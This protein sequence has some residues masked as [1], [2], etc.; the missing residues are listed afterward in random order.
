MERFAA[1]YGRALFPNR[2]AVRDDSAAGSPTADGE[3]RL[4][5][6]PAGLDL[7]IGAG[8]Y[9]LV[10]AVEALLGGLR[11]RTRRVGAATTRPPTATP[12]GCG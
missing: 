2:Y 6:P 8:V 12:L 1:A 5:L 10:C 11:R 4:T 7:A 3:Q 9:R